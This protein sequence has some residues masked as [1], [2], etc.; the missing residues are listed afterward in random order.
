MSDGDCVQ[1]PLTV[2]DVTVFRIR[3][4]MQL[5]SRVARSL[6]WGICIG[7]R[8]AEGGLQDQVCCHSPRR[9]IPFSPHLLTEPSNS[10]RDTIVRGARLLWAYLACFALEGNQIW[11]RT[12]RQ[13]VEVAQ[14]GTG[15]AVGSQWRGLLQP[16]SEASVA[17]SPRCCVMTELAATSAL[18]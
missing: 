13:L 8:L 7:S 18:G 4:L 9:G 12:I 16:S 6:G 2:P 17:T 15:E 10:P 3:Q 1:S 5:L 14:K 11:T